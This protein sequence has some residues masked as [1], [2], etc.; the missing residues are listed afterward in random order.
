MRLNEFASAADT[1]A[2]WK[3]ISDNTWA[4][5]AQQA[6]AEARA[7]AERAAARKSTS[8]RSGR[9]TAKPVPPKR[10]PPPLQHVTAPVPKDSKSTVAASTATGAN[11]K[12]QSTVQN[13]SQPLPSAFQSQQP[14]Q[15][16]QVGAVATQAIPNQANLASQ[17]QFAR[18]TKN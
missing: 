9:S 2:L 11:V 14:I 4:A 7:N 3:M 13:P 10:L 17:T 5:V 6:E 8:K 1:M 12:Q 18:N 15:P 16:T